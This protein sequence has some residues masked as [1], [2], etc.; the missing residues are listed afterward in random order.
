MMVHPEKKINSHA[1]YNVN[2]ML[3]HAMTKILN[4]AKVSNQKFA[5][6][7]SR[8]IQNGVRLVLPG[9]LAQH[10][11]SEGT[12]SVTKYSNNEPSGNKAA[13]AGLTV[14]PS[15]LERIMRGRGC[16]KRVGESAPVYLAAVA[17]YLIAEIIE[18]SGNAARDNNHIT[19]TPR[20][21]T[22]AMK[23]DEELNVLFDGV[24]NGG[25][26]PNIHVALL[27]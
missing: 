23:G 15:L 11:V 21:I 9:Q 25:V 1:V 5:T 8:A 18:L 13:R 2:L 17:E 12:K 16:S 7:S 19:I 10:A 27:K 26:V 6:L 3:H 14:P 4:A 22:L 24:Y 20:D